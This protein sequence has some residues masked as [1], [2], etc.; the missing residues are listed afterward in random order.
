MAVA[1]PEDHW[2]ASLPD[3]GF[4][5]HYR[6]WDGLRT[7]YVDEGPRDGPVALLVHGQPTWSYLYR[8]MIP[9][10]VQAG[11]RCIAPDHIGFGR[12]DKRTDD[13]WYTIA[14]HVDRLEALVAALDLRRITLF[15]QDWGGPIGLIG[16]MRDPGRYERFAILNTWLHTDDYQYSPA[17]RYWRET[18]CHPLWLSWTDGNLPCGA[19]AASARIRYEASDAATIRAAY[20][21]PFGGNP[22]AKAGARRFPACIPFADPVAGAADLQ[23]QAHAALRAIGKPVHFLFGEN[24]PIFPAA[25]GQ[26]WASLV[27]EATFDA[28]PRAGHFV[29]EDAPD[30]CLDLFFARRGADD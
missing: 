26:N 21:A 27:P 28:I 20:E 15:V 4:A 10:L 29:Q 16:A 6:E 18:A 14:R 11:Y 5:P 24:D 2:F 25:S 1:R 3:F 7:H 30:E 17:I 22:A 12:S 19:I 9:R 23:S 13:S 8:K